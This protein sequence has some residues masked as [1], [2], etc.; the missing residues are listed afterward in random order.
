MFYKNGAAI[1]SKP[2]YNQV[3]DK[4]NY[5]ARRNNKI[6]EVELRNDAVRINANVRTA[7][8]RTSKKNRN[9]TETVK[10]R[11]TRRKTTTA[12]KQK[13]STNIP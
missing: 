2:V 7:E 9:I 5:F 3:R 6:Y 13:Q 11:T 8:D 10:T 12:S 4:I 1:L